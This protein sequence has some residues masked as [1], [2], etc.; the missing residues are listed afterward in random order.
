MIRCATECVIS[1]ALVIR[2]ATECIISVTHVFICATKSRISVAHMFICATEIGRLA[3]RAMVGA[4]PTQILWRI[5]STC[6]T[7]KYNLVAHIILSATK[8]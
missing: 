8:I 7:E 5:S 2:C 6:A 1:V 3:S 4:G